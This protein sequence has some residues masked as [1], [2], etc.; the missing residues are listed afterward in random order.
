MKTNNE[1]NSVGDYFWVRLITVLAFIGICWIVWYV[2]I[3]AIMWIPNTLDRLE[4]LESVSY[5]EPQFNWEQESQLKTIANYVRATEDGSL[6]MKCASVSQKNCK[7]L[8]DEKPKEEWYL[9]KGGAHK[10]Q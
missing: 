5:N 9:F 10:S 8:P 2:L 3:P 4:K 6:Y 1:L 7:A